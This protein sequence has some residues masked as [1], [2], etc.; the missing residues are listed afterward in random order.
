MAPKIYNKWVSLVRKILI[1]TSKKSYIRVSP[2][3]NYGGCSLF[4][5]KR[6]ILIPPFFQKQKHEP[7][8]WNLKIVI[9][10]IGETFTRI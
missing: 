8:I 5:V 6:E 10:L 3:R 4:V 9:A 7:K 1:Q 2:K